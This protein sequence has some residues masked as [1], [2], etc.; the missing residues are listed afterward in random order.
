[1]TYS[2][3]GMMKARLSMLA[4]ILIPLLQG[5]A[6]TAPGDSTAARTIA[7]WHH[8][9]AGEG[10]KLIQQAVDRFKQDHPGVSV[11][12]VAIN[13]DAYKTKIKVAIGAGNA[14][15]VFPTW[16]GGP[17]RE[18]VKANQIVDLTPFITKDNYKDRFPAAA[19]DSITFDGKI[20]GVPVE[21]TA[22]A[23]IIYNKAIFQKYNIKPPATDTELFAIMRTLKQNGIA[24]FALANKPKWPGS[25]FYMYFVDRLAGPEA[26]AK[27]EAR[28][29]G[30]FE[31]PAFIEAGRRVQ[32]L[33]KD[34]AFQ[35]GFNGLDYDAGATRA[36]LYSG[37]AAMELMGTWTIGAINGENPTFYHENLAFF[38]FPAVTGGTGDPKNL[39]GTVGDNFYSVSPTCK[40]PENAFKLIQYLI[41]DTS[42]AARA[43]AGRVPPV[44]GFKTD[45]VILQQVIDMV[46][47]APHVQLWYDQQ[48]P[49]AV[50]EAHKDT[51]QAL[52]SMSMTPE[53]AARRME[54]AAKAY[55][56]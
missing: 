7:I 11:E 47:Q 31:S 12:V 27:A 20:Y 16:G 32:G 53:E 48:L 29:D 6:A 5:C 54:E 36:L 24:P 13:N 22:I 33:V 30:G 39:I 38:P 25:M 52:F 55:Y 26:F 44:K 14:P 37:K 18:Y 56:K 9:T 3:R 46:A 15:C 21:N 45:D 23:V 35:E 28:Q 43:K 4:A 40:D 42:V 19:F 2:E 8:Q 10:P 1:M 34:G 17:L 51:S 49:P 41:D 50:G